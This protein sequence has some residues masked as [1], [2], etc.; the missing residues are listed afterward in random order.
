MRLSTTTDPAALNAFGLPETIRLIARAGFDAYD[1]NLGYLREGHFLA[2]DDYR[3]RVAEAKAA[4][5]EAG[6]VCNQAH[7]PFMSSSLKIYGPHPPELWNWH[8]RSFAIAAELGAPAIVVHTAHYFPKGE[9]AFAYNL[10]YYQKLEP[11]AR[12][13]GLKIALE[14]LFIRDRRS[15]CLRPDESCAFPEDLLRY[16]EALDSDV[17]TV[18]LDVGHSGLIGDD[19]ERYLR[20]LGG[21]RI[22]ALHVHDNDFKQD[23]HTLPFLGKLDWESLA[24]ALA[25]SGYRGDFTFEVLAFQKKLPPELMEAAYG[26]LAQVGRYLISRIEAYR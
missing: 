18:C 11:L 15:E 20:L 21:D 12:E 8:R 26:Y 2:G 24:K 9:D 23:Q 19:A 1:I 25:E 10:A 4:A 22:T 14:N 6:I 13:Y 3:A 16:L 7:A 5:A 17:F